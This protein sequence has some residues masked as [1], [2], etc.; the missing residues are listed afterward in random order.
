MSAVIDSAKDTVD[1]RHS[2]KRRRRKKKSDAKNA[3][4][5][6]SAR[7]LSDNSRYLLCLIAQENESWSLAG[8]LIAIKVIASIALNM[9]A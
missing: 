4:G 2:N 3:I 6:G 7:V 8:S 1:D 9:V 5:A